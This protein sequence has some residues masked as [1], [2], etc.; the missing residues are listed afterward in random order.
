[1]TNVHHIINAVT[2][3]VIFLIYICLNNEKCVNLFGCG[4]DVCGV[5][6][7]CVDEKCVPL[8]KEVPIVIDPTQVPI[9]SEVIDP[10]QVGKFNNEKPTSARQIMVTI[11]LKKLL[12]IISLQRQSML[13]ESQSQRPNKS[14][15]KFCVILYFL[16]FN[17]LSDGQAYLI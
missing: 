5:D 9:P 11:L 12:M 13:I 8:N 15:N 1:M 7:R 10:T 16:K 6:Q 4:G 14:V 3:L 2:L 17:R